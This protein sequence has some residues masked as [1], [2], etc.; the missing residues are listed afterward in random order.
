[1]AASFSLGF[2]H[3]IM[4]RICLHLSFPLCLATMVLSGCGKKEETASPTVPP[5]APPVVLVAAAT[6]ED[7]ATTFAEAIATLDGSTNTI[8]RAQV[9]GYLIKQDYHEGDSVKPGDLLFEIDSG[10][11]PSGT[12]PPQPMPDNSAAP[13]HSAPIRITAPVGGVMG[14]ATPGIGDLIAPG[15]EMATVSTADP[16]KAGFRVTEQFY[17]HHANEINKLSA[18]PLEQRPEQLELLLP[19]GVLYS[20][21]GR[22]DSIVRQTQGPTSTIMVYALFPNPENLLHPGQDAR[23]HGV[24]GGVSGAVIVPRRAVSEVQGNDQV[25]VMKPDHTV[26]MRTVIAGEF[27][28]SSRIVLTGLKVGEWVVVEG[29]DKC[30]PGIIV[31]PQSYVPSAAE[32]SK[33]LLPSNAPVPSNP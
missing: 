18:L 12:N 7:V 8:V 32:K 14:K 30:Q 1:M 19:G 16:I 2:I 29:A 27:V 11:P 13:S 20:H 15:G 21:K 31:A 23:I 6:M 3:P 5:A 26:E 22:F 33:P 24:T 9:S 25:A 4:R 28:G 10:A 17:L